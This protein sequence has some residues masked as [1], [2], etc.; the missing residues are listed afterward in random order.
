MF[1][2]MPAA[3]DFLLTVEGG[4]IFSHAL[5]ET[6]AHTFSAESENKNFNKHF[7]KEGQLERLVPVQKK[8]VITART[9]TK[10]CR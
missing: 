4:S 2:L 9:P 7:T 1:W 5:I 6:D 8:S 3:Q 10:Q